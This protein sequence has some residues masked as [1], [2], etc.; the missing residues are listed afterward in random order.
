MR[1]TRRC[2][3]WESDTEGK[4]EKESPRRHGLFNS[5]I[6]IGCREGNSPHEIPGVDRNTIMKRF[7]LGGP[8]LG[9]RAC[10]SRREKKV[11]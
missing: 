9:E 2:L 7:L 5:G 1:K 3:L 8:G 11:G 6:I 4:R 10:E